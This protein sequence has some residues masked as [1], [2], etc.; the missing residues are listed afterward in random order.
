MGAV[1]AAGDNAYWSD[2]A[3]LRN[4]PICKLVK[5]DA[6]SVASGAITALGFGAG[7]EEIKTHASMHSVSTN[8]TR[9]TVPISGYYE[10]KMNMTWAFNTTLQVADMIVY[11][12]GA[13]VSYSGNFKYTTPV[14]N[15]VAL[16]GQHFTDILQA[17]AGDYFEMRVRHTSVSAAA[18]TTQ[19]GEA[20]TRFTVKFERPL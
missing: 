3:D 12:N 17:A 11:Q 19:S 1:V 13:I 15:N 2:L 6:V 5:Q 4:K 18:Q 9:I 16:G 10:I 14:S 20:R 8:N 7:S